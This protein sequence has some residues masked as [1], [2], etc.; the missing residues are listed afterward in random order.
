MGTRYR[1][2]LGHLRGM[3]SVSKAHA[4]GV[5]QNYPSV[6]QNYPSVYEVIRT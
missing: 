5:G 4:G 3:Q 6:G 1:Y 2:D